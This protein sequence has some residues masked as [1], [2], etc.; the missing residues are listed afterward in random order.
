MHKVRESMKFRQDK[1]MDGDVPV[2]EF[3]VSGKQTGQK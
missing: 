1:P 2:D 3:V